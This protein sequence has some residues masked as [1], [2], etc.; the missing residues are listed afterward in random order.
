MKKFFCK[1]CI[2]NG[3]IHSKWD[4]EAQDWICGQEREFEPKEE[5]E[6]EAP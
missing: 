1:D 5:E 4:K 2:Y 6:E 3:C